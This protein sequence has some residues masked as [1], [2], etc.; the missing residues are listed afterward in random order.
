MLHA[1]KEPLNDISRF[2]IL[3]IIL[4]W[5]ETVAAGWNRDFCTCA[6]NIRHEL[7]AVISF[8]R[9]DILGVVLTDKFICLGDIM[10]FAAGE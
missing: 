10:R 5:V 8:V 1:I 6:L 4:S 7:I 9:Y 3:F 2:I